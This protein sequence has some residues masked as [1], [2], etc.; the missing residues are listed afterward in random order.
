MKSYDY[1]AGA[2][3]SARPGG[4]IDNVVMCMLGTYVSRPSGIQN[5]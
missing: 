1:W 5:E 2:G 3:G 4:L